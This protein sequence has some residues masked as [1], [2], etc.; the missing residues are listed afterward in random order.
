M[1]KIRVIDI[2]T[3]GFDPAD[4]GICE[5]GYCDVTSGSEGGWTV[6]LPVNALVNPGRSIPP[7]TSAVHHLIDSDVAGFPTFDAVGPNILRDTSVN[8]LCAHNAKFERG[9][10]S[11]EMTGGKEWICTYKCALRIWK[12]APSHSNQ[13]L[14]YFRNPEGLS[15]AVASV[16]HRAGPDA[17]VTAFHLRDML[18]GGAKIEHLVARSSQPALLIR[19]HIGKERGKL[20]S[21]VDPGFMSWLLDKD[22]DE[23]VK[24]TAKYWLAERAKAPA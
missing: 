5:I 22:F 11:D 18:D 23:D 20:W 9:F 6:Q 17:Y 1:T 7:E 19:C 13:A 2:E 21:E 15:R 3:T 10:I 16:A 4:D 8:F 24:F 14:R 12:D